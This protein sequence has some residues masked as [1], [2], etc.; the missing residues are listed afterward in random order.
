MFSVI[1]LYKIRESDCFNSLLAS[2]VFIH[3]VSSRHLS[4][5]MCEKGTH[6]FYETSARKCLVFVLK[7]LKLYLLFFCALTNQWIDQLSI[8]QQNSTELNHIN[9]KRVTC[10]S[11]NLSWDPAGLDHVAQPGSRLARQVLNAVR[12]STGWCNGSMGDTPEQPRKAE[13]NPEGWVTLARPPADD[14][15]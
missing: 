7:I 8:K 14:G 13:T 2:G 1:C 3:P 9:C 4:I 6:L 10:P 5:L 11:L 15:N 12:L